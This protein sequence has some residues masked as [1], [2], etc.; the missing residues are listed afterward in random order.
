MASK[1]RA[2]MKKFLSIIVAC[3]LSFAAFSQAGAESSSAHNRSVV[4]RIVTVYSAK[5]FTCEIKHPLPVFGRRVPV[6][7]RSIDLPAVDDK[8]PH[9][10]A[11][12]RRAK[13][14]TEKLLQQAKVITLE[15]MRR[16]GYSRI[17][18]D[19]YVDGRN[20][21]DL[22]ESPAL[23][24]SAESAIEIVQPIEQE[25][26]APVASARP[27]KQS[28]IQLPKRR[29]A[30][31]PRPVSHQLD[32]PV[33]LSVLTPDMPFAEAIDILRN[34]TDPPLNIVV[35]WKDLT[36]NAFIER[37]TPIGF[38]GPAH[39]PLATGLGLLLASVSEGLDELDYTVEKEVIV[40]ATK[41]YLAGRMVTRVYDITD[42]AQRHSGAP[43]GPFTG[44]YGGGG[45]GGYGT[46]QGYGSGPTNRFSPNT[47]R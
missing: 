27:E 43:F 37:N 26:K 4:T 1:G 40:I 35:L 34:V 10:Q 24:K 19:V 3:F 44:G 42:L 17:I 28:K 2:P 6:K 12:A 18:A 33:D 20:L 13:Q 25:N 31:H 39:I 23:T 30:K 22:L 7:L 16:D 21:A 36:N 46:N 14:L 15:N 47:R 11:L 45:Y 8:K 41:Q 5:A 9:A 29:P 32:Q 38:Q